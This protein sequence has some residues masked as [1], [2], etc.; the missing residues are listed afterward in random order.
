M[1]G[2]FGADTDALRELAGA[3]SNH[4]DTVRSGEARIT[5]EVSRP[6][7]WLGPDADAFRGTWES[8]T[9]P[10][11]QALAARLDEI[12]NELVR[13]AAEQDETSSGSGGRSFAGDK[14]TGP[15]GGNGGSGGPAGPGVD[16]AR[17]QLENAN[18]AEEV[19]E[20]WNSGQIS[21][22][23][24]REIIEKHPDLIRNLDGIPLNDRS[25]ANQQWAKENRERIREEHGADSDIANVVEQ[26]ANGDLKSVYL[27]PPRDIITMHGDLDADTKR[28]VIHNPATGGK[29]EDFALNE[30]GGRRG[31][32]LGI[33]EHLASSD[34]D[35][36]VLV[37]QTGDWAK[38]I[39]D[40]PFTEVPGIDDGPP[41]AND[42][43][44]YDKL[45]QDLARF[46]RDGL[47]TDPNITDDTKMVGTG[48]SFGNSVTTASEMHGAR[49][50]SVICIAGANTPPGW[51]PTDGTTYTQ[52]QYDNDFLNLANAP[53]HSAAG[54][55]IGG[56]SGGIG[57]GLTGAIEGG[58]SGA[59]EGIRR[60]REGGGNLLERIGGA[61]V[62]GTVGVVVGTGQGA[63]EG[64]VQGMQQGAQEGSAIGSKMRTPLGGVTEEIIVN[65]LFPGGNP[66]H[67]SAWETRNYGVVH[68]D[69]IGTGDFRE[70][71]AAKAHAQAG[72]YSGRA[73]DPNAQL[74]NDLRENVES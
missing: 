41:Y 4:S 50:D 64:A 1:A 8:V 48:F 30:E 45:G 35:T 25:A 15:G 27:D 39:G 24:K 36:V 63:V 2:M 16:A 69:P 31:G 42:P 72:T 51:T 9:G 19:T 46:Q 56:A 71:G 18:S 58:I 11:I 23:V 20:L 14:Y 49:Y 10:N 22:E 21:D 47:L 6:D 54:A 38:S 60:G 29:F 62:E 61:V 67:S 43:Q 40:V 52:Y 37:N 59:A 68:G 33:P 57:G 70:L 74:F 66:D 26:V 34:P 17:D 5:P 12:R 13:Q 7:Y 44:V 32:Y 73:D 28:V 55:V 65:E 3:A 53:G